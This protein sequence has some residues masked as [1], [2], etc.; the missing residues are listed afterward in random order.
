M[1]PPIFSGIQN[2]TRMLADPRLRIIVPNT[3]FLT[4]FAVTGNNV[5]GFLMAVLI[6][7]KLPAALRYFF[8]TAF[9][10]QCL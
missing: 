8:R 7:R 5:T 2:Y 1:S 6:N 9:F 3:V 4:I 10:F